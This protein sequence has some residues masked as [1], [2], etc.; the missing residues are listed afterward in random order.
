MRPDRFFR[1][2]P[3]AAAP[4]ARRA[5][6][7]R[8]NLDMSTPQPIAGAFSLN[9]RPVV[10]PV[11]GGLERWDRWA[12]WDE[13]AMAEAESGMAMKDGVPV[14]TGVPMG[15]MDREGR[16]GGVQGYARSARGR[17]ALAE[18]PRWRRWLA[19]VLLWVASGVGRAARF[20]GGERQAKTASG[21]AEVVRILPKGRDR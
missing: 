8:K 9:T 21:E 18:M 11:V 10:A 3:P 1:A 4:V 20:V 14:R 13:G 2:P 17:Q 7:V 5:P 15:Q 19:T 12:S 6:A 16:S